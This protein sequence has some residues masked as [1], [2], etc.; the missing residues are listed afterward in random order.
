MKKTAASAEQ[1]ENSEL[2]PGTPQT[3][4][5]RAFHILQDHKKKVL[6]NVNQ[7]RVVVTASMKNL[8]ELTKEKEN[9]LKELRK[10]LTLMNDV[11]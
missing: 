4:V 5:R 11:M 10:C 6:Q 8:A 1:Q 7:T 9:N 2:P 3:E